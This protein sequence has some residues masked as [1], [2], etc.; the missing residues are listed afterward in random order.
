MIVICSQRRRTVPVTMLLHLSEYAAT[1]SSISHYAKRIDNEAQGKKRKKKKLVFSQWMVIQSIRKSCLCDDLANKRF[2]IENPADPGWLIHQSYI[3][4]IK[5][6]PASHIELCL[7]MSITF[8][9]RPDT[10]STNQITSWC[11]AY[12]LRFSF[13]QTYTCIL[14][15][16]LPISISKQN[17]K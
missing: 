5:T 15:K 6:L 17:T 11:H 9:F 7:Q 8:L 10:C 4:S 2:V 14:S 16:C 3:T 13:T 12:S 1:Q